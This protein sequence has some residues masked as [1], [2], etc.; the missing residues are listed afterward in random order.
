MNDVG[1]AVMIFVLGFIVALTLVLS[2]QDGEIFMGM[3]SAILDCESQL[4]R[5]QKCE[6]EWQAVTAKEPK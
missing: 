4:P 6:I 5:N 1:L 3:S 2:T